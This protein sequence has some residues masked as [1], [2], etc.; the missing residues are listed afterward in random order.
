M[1]EEGSP[2]G[3]PGF[4]TDSI[5]DNS[6]YNIWDRFTSESGDVK[7]ENIYMND[8]KSEGKPAMVICW[9][10]QHTHAVM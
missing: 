3:L 1:T 8:I 4:I 6:L 7:V 10:C 2:G 5:M 9:H